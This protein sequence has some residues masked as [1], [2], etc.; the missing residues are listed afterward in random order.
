MI[1]FSSILSDA[2]YCSEKISENTKF[3]KLS[4]K[5]PFLNL[6]L[7]LASNTSS[8]DVSS[9]SK[10]SVTDSSNLSIL[11]SILPISRIVYLRLSIV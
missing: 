11:F 8:V 10:L 2:E 5:K 6:L 1:E 9:S 4:A 7:P 3:L